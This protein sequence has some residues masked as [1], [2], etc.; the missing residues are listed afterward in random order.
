VAAARST[1]D[2]AGAALSA[3]DP[4]ATLER[5]YAIVRRA[6]DGLIVREPAEV[7]V[8]DA[9]GIEVARGGIRAVVAGEDPS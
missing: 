6:A 5:G 4:G 1:V 9:L 7:A 2:A 3:L 8:G